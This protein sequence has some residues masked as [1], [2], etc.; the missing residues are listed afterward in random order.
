VEAL[1]ACLPNLT[2][3]EACDEV[4][5]NFCYVNSKGARKRMVRPQITTGASL[6]CKAQVGG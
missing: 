4:A 2:S 6:V 1:L 3:R 5:V